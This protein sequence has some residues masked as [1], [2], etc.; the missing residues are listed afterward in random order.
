VKPGGSPFAP[1]L[2]IRQ[3]VGRTAAVWILSAA[4]LA[5]FVGLWVIHP[6]RFDPNISNW[7]WIP[8]GVGAVAFVIIRLMGP[9]GGDPRRLE[10]T[11]AGL[12][13]DDTTVPW[14]SIS[15]IRWRFSPA[16]EI[17]SLTK[18]GS[19]FRSR[20]DTVPTTT[21]SITPNGLPANAATDPAWMSVFEVSLPFLSL[22]ADSQAVGQ[23]FAEACRAY[24]V[25][26]ELDL[27][28]GPL[29]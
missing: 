2:V 17:P 1:T 28:S 9:S 16:F 26:V 25:N 20:I 15:A 6:N 11:P 21:V 23:R 4:L 18:G 27:P 12:Q 7:A 24:G 19:S 14:S 10:I 29:S 22:H 13:V 3:G 8:I 5:A